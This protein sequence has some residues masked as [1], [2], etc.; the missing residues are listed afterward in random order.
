VIYGDASVLGAPG[1]WERDVWW[2]LNH[3][4]RVGKGTGRHRW[5]HKPPFHSS[6][7]STGRRLL[8]TAG[9]PRLPYG[10]STAGKAYLTHFP[11][12]VLFAWHDGVIVGRMISWW[13][14]SRTAYFVMQD[15]PTSP[16]CVP[17]QFRAIQAA[18]S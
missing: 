11:H 7:C 18:G 5:R 16:L 2:A 4:A 14:G 10:R 9:E 13:C 6:Y 15:E 1:T 17:C 12:T 8:V 3:G